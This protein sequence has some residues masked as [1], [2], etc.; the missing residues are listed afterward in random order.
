MEIGVNKSNENPYLFF[1]SNI[2]EKQI[3]FS[4]VSIICRWFGAETEQILKK[5][6]KTRRLRQFNRLKQ[7]HLTDGIAQRISLSFEM[8]YLTATGDTVNKRARFKR[9]SIIA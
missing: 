5:K 8:T 9:S 4:F 3:R 1:L 6:T 7:M 2:C